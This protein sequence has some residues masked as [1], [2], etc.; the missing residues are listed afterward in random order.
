M[1]LMTPAGRSERLARERSSEKHC[2]LVAELEVWFHRKGRFR[3]VFY[4]ISS[5][6]NLAVGLWSLKN[7]CDYR[8]PGR[9]ATSL[10]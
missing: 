10:D 7:N 3:K 9:G 6:M 8:F 4:R 2:W 5:A 1:V